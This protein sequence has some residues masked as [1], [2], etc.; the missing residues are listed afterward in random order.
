MN[1]T[2]AGVCAVHTVLIAVL[3]ISIP[4]ITHAAEPSQAGSH[5]TRCESSTKENRSAQAAA[6][7]RGIAWTVARTP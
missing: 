7:D 6:G 4:A 5:P 1:R 2:Y 3:T